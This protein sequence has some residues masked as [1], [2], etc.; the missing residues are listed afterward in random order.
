MIFVLMEQRF[1]LA[2]AISSTVSKYTIGATG[3]TYVGNV[4][5][6]NGANSCCFDGNYIWVTGSSN[7]FQISTTLSINGNYPFSGNVGIR[8]DGTY[9]WTIASGN[10]NK[11]QYTT[12]LTLMQTISIGGTLQG[13]CFDGTYIWVV[14]TSNQVIQISVVDG[15][16]IQ[17]ISLSY[18]PNAICFD[19]AHIWVGGG[20]V[21]VGYI[22]KI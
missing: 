17:T 20:S 5:S 7:I 8:F 9:L 12:T 14:S 4:P 19:G 11:Y 16:I 15:R 18:L 1:G 2:N 22:T 6:V 10:I 3:A 21:S 13:I